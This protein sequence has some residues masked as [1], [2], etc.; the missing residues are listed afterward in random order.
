[1]AGKMWFIFKW[2][3]NIF[4]STLSHDVSCVSLVTG[5]GAGYRWRGAVF[6]DHSNTNRIQSYLRVVCS[7]GYY[8]EWLSIA[9]CSS[10]ILILECTT[11]LQDDCAVVK[12]STAGTV[13]WG[14][15]WGLLAQYLL[16][17]VS[18]VTLWVVSSAFRNTAF[19][20]DT[21]ECRIQSAGSLLSVCL[22]RI[23]Q[24]ILCL[25]GNNL[26]F[27]PSRALVM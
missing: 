23:A 6:T 18:C 1:M 8:L 27:S 9:P 3:K 13:C 10:L 2:K 11:W 19:S 17:W 5:D 24:L 20:S 22:Y 14:V 26:S 21:L 15:N 12:R 7:D 4:L 25:P 16:C